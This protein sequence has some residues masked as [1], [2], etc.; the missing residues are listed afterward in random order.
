M[1]GGAHIT[2][3]GL[4]ENIP[5][6]LPEGCRAVIDRGSWP[7]PPIFRRIAREGGIGDEDMFRTF[8]M[9]IGMVLCLPAEQAEEAKARAESLGE[10][11]WIIGRVTEGS[12]GVAWGRGGLSM[13][14]AVFASGSGSNFQALV[15]AL[16]RRRTWPE[17]IRLLVCDRPGARVLERARSLGVPSLLVDPKGSLQGRLR[18][19]N[20]GPPPAGGD[21]TLVLA[22][23]MR[24]IGSTLLD[25]Y[26][27]RIVNIHPSLLP[28]F[29]GKDAVGQALDYGVKWTGVT[30]HFVDEG[31]DTGPIIAQEPVRDRRGGRPRI[32]HPQDPGGGAPALS[33]GDL[34]L[35][36]RPD[37]KSPLGHHDGSVR[38]DAKFP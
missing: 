32:A 31:M 38:K 23:Y 21:P 1:K 28:A 26:R 30:V 17:P 33:G 9:G 29:P 37:Q 22:G 16:P 15:E 8:N 12:R 34:G 14:I 10:R 25:A 4:V 36:Q 20:P 11:A 6:M 5:R 18:G 19:G 24:L 3:G 35:D 27:W 2:G 7:V 13:S